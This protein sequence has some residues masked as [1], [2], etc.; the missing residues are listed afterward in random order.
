MPAS[1]LYKRNHFPSLYPIFL[2]LSFLEKK[3]A[4]D[5]DLDN[6]SHVSFFA[7]SWPP[8]IRMTRADPS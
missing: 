3:E 8:R 2:I 6:F 1:H 5:L 4:I 7:I